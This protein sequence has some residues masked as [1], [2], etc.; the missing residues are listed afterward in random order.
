[1][2][3]VNMVPKTIKKVI[4]DGDFI[5]NTVECPRCISFTTKR[6]HRGSII[7]SLL[8]F[9][10]IKRYRCEKC[11]NKFYKFSER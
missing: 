6:I 8:F 9:L 4:S 5:C 11:Q 1:M 3:I 10:P 7:K 2:K